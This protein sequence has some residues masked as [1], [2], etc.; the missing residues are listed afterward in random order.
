MSPTILQ[1]TELCNS[2]SSGVQLNGKK[3]SGK[4]MEKPKP[5]FQPGEQRCQMESFRSLDHRAR[6]GRTKKLASF[7][8]VSR[9]RRCTSHCFV[10]AICSMLRASTEFGNGRAR[11]SSRALFFGTVGQWKQRKKANR[12]LLDVRVFT[13][14]GSSWKMLFHHGCNPLPLASPP[15]KLVVREAAFETAYV[16]GSLTAESIPSGEFVV[17]V[18]GIRGNSYRWGR[19]ER[20]RENGMSRA[21]C[22][23]YVIKKRAKQ[24][25]I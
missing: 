23:R 10:R 8:T 13:G 6:W 25:R 22:Y 19:A 4:S 24:I 14:L 12:I 17:V 18:S 20:I 16:H 1:I 3:R 7:Q 11:H 2:Y 9:G 5:V 21:E 15:D